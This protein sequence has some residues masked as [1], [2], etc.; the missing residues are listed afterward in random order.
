MPFLGSKVLRTRIIP[1]KAT[2][3]IRNQQVAGSIPAGGSRHLK[4]YQ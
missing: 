1:E 4:Q 3:R 2:Y